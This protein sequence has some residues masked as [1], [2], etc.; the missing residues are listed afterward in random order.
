MLG[1]TPTRSRSVDRE[2]AEGPCQECKSGEYHY[3]GGDA[4]R[5]YFKCDACGDRVRVVE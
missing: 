1:N 5:D 2:T 4:G 3:A